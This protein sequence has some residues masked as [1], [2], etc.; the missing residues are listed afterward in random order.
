MVSS[1][2]NLSKAATVLAM[3]LGLAGC[4]FSN[5]FPKDPPEALARQALAQRA[6]IDSLKGAATMKIRDWKNNFF[7][8]FDAEIIARR[9]KDLHIHAT[10]MGDRIEVFDA[11]VR[12]NKIAMLVPSEKILYVGSV[13]DSRRAN[14]QLGPEELLNRLFGFDP[15]LRQRAWKYHEIRAHLTGRR[16]V[17]LT[18]KNP[19]DRPHLRFIVEDGSYLLHGIEHVNASGEVKLRELY[20]KYR[21][22]SDFTGQQPPGGEEPMVPL[23]LRLIWPQESREVQLHFSDLQANGEVGPF[24]L[25]LSGGE[26][27]MPLK[28]IR[29]KSDEPEESP[30]GEDELE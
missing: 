6:A 23:S 18:E 22:L 2:A 9:P 20:S 26:R 24:T 25:S 14:I 7:L 28:D 5:K 13:E 19:D 1:L 11:V 17:I 29:M 30:T 16:N 27:R 4:V 10:K 21:P 8:T 15:A 12:G 3:L